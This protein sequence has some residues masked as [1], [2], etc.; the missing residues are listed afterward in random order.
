MTHIDNKGRGRIFDTIDQAAGDAAKLKGHAAGVAA[1]VVT[2]MVAAQKFFGELFGMKQVRWEGKTYMVNGRSLQ[3]FLDRNPN[4]Q[5]KNEAGK[6]DIDQTL[7]N[8]CEKNRVIFVGG[9]S[10]SSK[11]KIDALKGDFDS[12][13]D[14]VSVSIEELPRILDILGLKTDVKEAIANALTEDVR[15]GNGSIEINKNSFMKLISDHK[16][17]LNVPKNLPNELKALSEVVV[18]FFKSPNKE[19]VKTQV[20][21]VVFDTV[22]NPPSEASKQISAQPVKPSSDRVSV[23]NIEVKTI[24][25]AKDVRIGT[26]ARVL[27][28]AKTVQKEPKTYADMAK[29]PIEREKAA[30]AAAEKFQEVCEKLI[31]MK[32]KFEE[33]GKA[34]PQSSKDPKVLKGQVKKEFGEL[35]EKFVAAKSEY[36]RLE[37]SPKGLE[38]AEKNLDKLINTHD[39]LSEELDRVINE[40]E[41]KRLAGGKPT[42][43]QAATAQK[44]GASQE[45]ARNAYLGLKDKLQDEMGLFERLAQVPPSSVEDAKKSI[46]DI[47]VGVSMIRGEI[48]AAE[49]KYSKSATAPGAKKT[50]ED[51]IRG[52]QSAIKQFQAGTTK[53][54]DGLTK[55]GKALALSEAKAAKSDSEDTSE[56]DA[57]VVKP[58]AK[59][60]VSATMETTHISK[61]T[62]SKTTESESVTRQ[63]ADPRLQKLSKYSA[64][65]DA[66]I[67]NCPDNMPILKKGLQEIK[68]QLVKAE[69]QIKRGGSITFDEITDVNFDTFSKFY[70]TAEGKKLD[71]FYETGSVPEELGFVAN[72][73]DELVVTKESEKVIK[74][75]HKKRIENFEKKL[76]TAAKSK[77]ALPSEISTSLAR[78]LDE[79]QQKEAAAKKQLKAATV[80]YTAA[81]EQHPI[82][83][84]AMIEDYNTLIDTLNGDK[85]FVASLKGMWG[86]LG[87]ALPGLAEVVT[88]KD[89]Y[90]TFEK[91]LEVDL[92]KLNRA[93]ILNHLEAF[94]D[95][96]IAGKMPQSM[97]SDLKDFDKSLS[98]YEA[99]TNELHASRKAFKEARQEVSDLGE[100][101]LNKSIY[102][103]EVELVETRRSEAKS[104]KGSI[105]KS[106]QALELRE[107]L[108]RQAFVKEFKSLCEV[109]LKDPVVKTSLS[110]SLGAI[111]RVTGLSEYNT[112]VKLARVDVSKL[113]LH[114][115]EKHVLE[116]GFLLD[117]AYEEGS[118]GKVPQ[119]VQKQVESFTNSLVEYRNALENVPTAKGDATRAVLKKQIGFTNANVERFTER[120][121]ELSRLGDTKAARDVVSQ[122]AAKKQ[123]AAKVAVDPKAALSSEQIATLVPKDTRK[124]LQARFNALVADL[125][126]TSEF[127]AR[128]KAGTGK[129]LYNDSFV[130][131]W[132]AVKKEISEIGEQKH[133]PSYIRYL[134]DGTDNEGFAE[135]KYVGN[136]L[137][138]VDTVF[139]EGVGAPKELLDNLK[140]IWEL[141]AHFEIVSK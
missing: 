82:A 28:Q 20:A 50:L 109:V 60:V 58:A 70:S 65:L 106:P 62:I 9:K 18:K 11:E 120:Q 92:S 110:K 21:N 81:K 53:L 24:P 130:D 100:L 93:E 107:K 64:K 113:P 10:V 86:K 46:D 137:D 87:R 41:T 8:I 1:R 38:T 56:G 32:S 103:R 52:M 102:L 19:Q 66:A 33:E 95:L 131:S 40:N 54:I 127:A 99:A 61:S 125:E 115:L 97:I 122:F 91:F 112:L 134:F 105:T 27:Q 121:E 25:E 94:H 34:L 133:G 17:E 39:H 57:T 51:D 83:K 98:A 29:K 85:E 128:V 104:E 69:G 36:I 108:T 138:M 49:L 116:F 88:L 12:A 124:A 47:R 132:N 37:K 111:G 80:R 71:R 14:V 79:L 114:A 89:K 43:A 2:K 96:V 30:A 73:L 45:A 78:Q 90:T 77:N 26:A 5:V 140:T 117:K 7:K 141:A 15:A 118:T 35:R 59:P 6:I 48:G 74:P 101:L 119:N 13:K 68:E 63:E 16:D 126:G 72:F 22:I 4:F 31:A 139:P 76:T 75:I 129:W 136:M 44:P 3:H 84:E 23:R 67:N 55:Q 123:D 135:E 42:F